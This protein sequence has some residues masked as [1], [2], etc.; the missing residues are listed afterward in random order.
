MSSEPGRRD[1]VRDP[2]AEAEEPAA[3]EL[4]DVVKRF[5]GHEV[6]RGLNLAIRPREAMTIIG[7]SGA[8]KSVL[9]RLMIGLIKPDQ[10]RILIEGQ[11]IVPLRERELLRVRCKLGMIFQGSALFDSMTVG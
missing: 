6:I 2:T 10:G 7:G 11:D 8:G 4:R 9:L 1:A 3:L 5:E